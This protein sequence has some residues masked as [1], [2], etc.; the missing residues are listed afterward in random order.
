MLSDGQRRVWDAVHAQDAE[1]IVVHGPIRSGKTYAAAAAWVAWCAQ[2]APGQTVGLVGHTQQQIDRVM[3]PACREIAEHVGLSWTRAGVGW[4]LATASWDGSPPATV[5][6]LVAGDRGSETRA[7]G[8]TF[9]TAWL[10]EAAAM[11]ETTVHT[12]LDRCSLPYARSVLSTQPEGPGHWI[13]RDLIQ[14]A[15]GT[16]LH[17]VPMTLA[18]NPSLPANYEQRL[19]RRY[20]GPLA[21]RLID[22][23]WVAQTG[24]V[25]PAD[26][27]TA[28]VGDPPPSVWEGPCRLAVDPAESTVTHA[29]LTTDVG[30][31]GK[32]VRWVMAEWRH[33]HRAHGPLPAWEQAARIRRDLVGGRDVTVCHVDP[34]APDMISALTEELGRVVKPAI[35]KPLL[36]ALKYVRDRLERGRLMIAAGRAG[37]LVSEMLGYRWDNAATARGE[38]RPVKEN[39]H[40]CDALRYDVWTRPHS[41]VR[42]VRR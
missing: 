7:R 11:P 35:S 32:R 21:R 40:S 18:D 9:A 2:W 41:P 6:P 23:E 29:L 3:A 27:I 4:E 25:W 12:V 20:Q 24:L 28:A 42:V 34:S 26:A 30:Q 39:D 10:D 17:A 13:N 5:V 19:R 31:P 16:E 1:T 38:D 36:P 37:T 14:T 8:F 33:D 22:G 15:D